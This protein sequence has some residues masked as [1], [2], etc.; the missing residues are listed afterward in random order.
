MSTVFPKLGVLN[1][2]IVKTLN[3][4]AGNNL[5]ASKLMSWIRISSAVKGGNGYNGLI[6]ETFPKKINDEGNVINSTFKDIYGNERQS[7]R[8]GIDFDGKPVYAD[9]EDRGFRPSPIIESITVENGTSG[10]SRKAKFNIICY[11]LPQAE[12]I[13]KH[14]L[15]PG[16][17][18]LVEYGWNLPESLNEKDPVSP[19][20]MANFNSYTFI[21]NKRTR[22][23][24]TY[25][26][27]MGFITGGGF[28]SGD[29]ETYVVSVELTT[30]GEIPSYLQV[31]K[32]AVSAIGDS[33]NESKTSQTYTV[34]E[35]EQNSGNKDQI[36]DGLFKQMFMMLPSEKRTQQIKNILNEKDANGNLFSSEWN[37]INVD[38]EVR[39]TFIENLDTFLATKTDSDGDKNIDFPSGLDII[40]DQSFI[41]AELAFKILNSY[42]MNLDPV[43]N[44]NSKCTGNA[45]KI[46]SY[47]FTISTNKTIIGAHKHM[48]STDITKLYIPNSNLPDF[49]LEAVL[50]SNLEVNADDFINVSNPKTKNGNIWIDSGN[51]LTSEYEFPMNRAINDFGF[52]DVV[53]LK[54]VREVVSKPNTWGYLRNLYINLNFFI[55][56]ITRPNFVA[57]DCYYEILN[58]ISSAANSYWQFEIQENVVRQQVPNGSG[59]FFDVNQMQITDQNFVGGVSKKEVMPSFEPAGPKTPF[60][61]SNI[62]IDIPAAMKNSILG[63]RSSANI[64]TSIEGFGIKQTGLFATE[65]DPVMEILD[66]WKLGPNGGQSR[67]EQSIANDRANR[68]FVIGELAKQGITNREPTTEELRSG[69]ALKKKLEQTNTTVGDNRLRN[70]EQ[71]AQ[72]GTLLLKIRDKAK[73]ST[74]WFSQNIAVIGKDL[75]VGAYDDPTLLKRFEISS[76]GIGSTD[77]LVNNPSILGIEFTFETLGISGI[78]IGDTFKVTRLPKQYK[79]GIFQVMETSHNLTDG[80]WSTTVTARLRNI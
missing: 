20:Y 4:R 37:F 70:I 25:D 32:T 69:P 15:E 64:E 28:T 11:T 1:E 55:E 63:K 39:E 74:N 24:G 41:R 19:C 60:I 27:F 76:S 78:K 56:V 73:V 35:I 10:L 36:G 66:S 53:T 72:K 62:N 18:V 31:Q 12:L 38:K 3:E 68:E 54:D 16:Y 59:N 42:G 26:G 13:T 9:G 80:T 45:T 46:P 34:S 75:I 8:V 23:K 52:E 65:I 58:G 17:T 43:M 14:F 22:S 5:L 2:N 48:F 57:K 47:D 40:T 7:G 33:T 79:T 71:F 6:L 67:V 29:D 77:G 44:P 21:L 50:T 49:G 30:L 51:D 61:T